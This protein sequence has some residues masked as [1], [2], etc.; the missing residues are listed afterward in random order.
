MNEISKLINL[1]Q[2]FLNQQLKSQ[3]ELFTLIAHTAV[4]NKIAVDET[5][6][7]QAFVKREQETSTGLQDEFAIPHAK[8]ESILL[9]AIFFVANE[10]GID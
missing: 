6:V 2:I 7:I 10:K 8:D 9:P 4:K 5:A 3:L 1:N